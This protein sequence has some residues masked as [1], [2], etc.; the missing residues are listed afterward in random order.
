M[1]L[2]GVTFWP[3]KKKQELN[4]IKNN[5]RLEVNPAG[6]ERSHT[7]AQKE[8]GGTQLEGQGCGGRWRATVLLLPL[9]IEKIKDIIDSI[10]QTSL[11]KIPWNLS[12][13]N[14]TGCC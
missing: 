13:G 6:L 5:T 4:K 7:K 11:R 14:L 3:N 2:G 12:P 9:V 10:D 8:S 1:S